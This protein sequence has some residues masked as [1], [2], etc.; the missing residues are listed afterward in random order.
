MRNQYLLHHFFQV[1]PSK[2]TVIFK[3]S[4]T[5]Q[6]SDDIGQGEKK[7]KR[8]RDKFAHYIT[9]KDVTPSKQNKSIT[10]LHKLLNVKY[11][12]NAVVLTKNF[13]ELVS[14]VLYFCI[15]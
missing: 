12:N 9:S 10:F 2:F 4:D 1:F 6:Q 14:F 15:G 8:Q 3:K 5:I 13:I 11:I 7:T